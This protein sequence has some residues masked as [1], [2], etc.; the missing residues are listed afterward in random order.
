MEQTLFQML[1]MKNLKFVVTR[2]FSASDT[3]LK[4]KQYPVADPGFP[5]QR[6]PTSEIGANTYYLT[7][8]LAKTA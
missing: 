8:F 1:G 4:A 5:R 7:R 2:D 6:A 3:S